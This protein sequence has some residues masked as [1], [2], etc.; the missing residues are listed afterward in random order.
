M[1]TLHEAIRVV[2]EELIKSECLRQQKKSLHYLE[3][4][5]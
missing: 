1:L 3:P 4:K 2:Q 5:N